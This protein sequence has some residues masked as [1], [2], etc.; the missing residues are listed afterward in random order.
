MGY[1]QPRLQ[2]DNLCAKYSY[3]PNLS[4]SHHISSFLF[5][6]SPHQKLW[7]WLIWHKICQIGNTVCLCNCL[8]GVRVKYHV[9][10]LER[11]SKF[12][13]DEMAHAGSASSSALDALKTTFA[14]RSNIDSLKA[15]MKFIVEQLEM[16]VNYTDIFQSNS[17]L[18]TQVTY[19]SLLFYELS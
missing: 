13:D 11:Y 12:I 5:S 14:E 2:Q 8:G 1:L 3:Y 15:Q 18:A 17:P 7:Y 19:F 16:F 4:K 9:N 6:A 10:K